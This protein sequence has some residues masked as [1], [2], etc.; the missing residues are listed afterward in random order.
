MRPNNYVLGFARLK[1]FDPNSLYQIESTISNV[2]QD[3]VVSRD[4]IAITA[5]TGEAIKDVINYERDESVIQTFE[6]DELFLA[7]T[8]ATVDSVKAV[9]MHLPS[10]SEDDVLCVRLERQIYLW[11]HEL[12]R[13]G[14]QSDVAEALVPSRPYFIR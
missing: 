6:E 9:L 5:L 3:S 13:T 4:A 7:L 1:D 11:E 14:V 10:R 12:A 2:I 8:K